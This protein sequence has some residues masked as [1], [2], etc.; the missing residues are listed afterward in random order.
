MMPAT[1]P[2]LKPVPIPTAAQ[3][4]EAEKTIKEVFKDEF[5]KTAVPDKLAFAKNLILNGDETRDDDAARYML[6][7]E[8]AHQAAQAADIELLFAVWEKIAAEFSG[9]LKAV[10]GAGWTAF[11]ASTKDPGLLKLATAYKTLLDK[12][13][14]LGAMLALARHE[15]FTLGNWERG[16]SLF[17]KS[18]NAALSAA[19]RQ[20]IKDP[21]E[22]AAQVA[23]GDLWWDLGDKER[24]KDDKVLYQVRAAFWYRLAMPSLNGLVKV[25]YDTR[26]AKAESAGAALLAASAPPALPERA[27]QLR[28][29]APQPKDSIVNDENFSESKVFPKGVYRLMRRIH[30]AGENLRAT[31][32]A[33]AEFSE[34][35]I[36]FGPNGRLLLNGEEEAPWFFTG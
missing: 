21:T 8:A 4:K 29:T 15:C 23:L 35:L 25:R 14:D 30:F 24:D 2:S 22:S 1:P 27:V 5:A 10:K 13:D 28:P 32:E 16:M 19:A 12:P 33:G 18:P 34:G 26:A 31:I 3:Q 20:D 17:A 9:D 6:L 11:S 7:V 36:E